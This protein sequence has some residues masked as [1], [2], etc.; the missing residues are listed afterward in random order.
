VRLDVLSSTPAA[1]SPRAPC[2]HARL[3]RLA[4]KSGEQSGL[5]RNI[6]EGPSSVSL[7]QLCFSCG[8]LMAIS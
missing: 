4:T 6:H 5:I 7:L 1:L 8:R 2:I 3:R